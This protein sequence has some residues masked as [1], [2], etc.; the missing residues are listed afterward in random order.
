MGKNKLGEN[1]LKALLAITL[2]GTG[3]S[4]LAE[5]PQES[6]DDVVAHE[7]QMEQSLQV[8]IESGAVQLDP[9]TGQLIFTKDFTKHLIDSGIIDELPT[10]LKSSSDT[11]GWPCSAKK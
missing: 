1:S 3:T 9:K 4:A 5:P 7:A 6:K 10:S 2:G 11:G 8:L